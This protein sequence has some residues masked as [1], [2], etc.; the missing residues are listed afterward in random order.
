MS[1]PGAKTS[2]ACFTAGANFLAPSNTL[3]RIVAFNGVESTWQTV[4]DGAYLGRPMGIG[5]VSE[6]L[7]LVSNNEKSSDSVH[8]MG[9]MGEDLGVFASVFGPS[10]I[11]PLPDKGLVA[12]GESDESAV[13][14]FDVSQRAELGRP[15]ELTDAVGLSHMGTLPR[16]SDIGELDSE[17]LTTTSNDEVQRSCI[18]NESSCK[19]GLRKRKLLIDAGA[20]VPMG[21]AILGIGTLRERGS[22]LVAIR[23]PNIH[24]RRVYECPLNEINTPL[25][26]CEIFAGSPT[27]SLTLLPRPHLLF[28]SPANSSPRS[29]SLI[30]R[31]PTGTPGTSKLTRRNAL[32]TCSTTRTPPCTCSPSTASTSG[33]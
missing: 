10:V 30:I 5:C 2:S 3:N 26:G 8:M 13:L 19:P 28:T 25:S 9:V 15:L 4:V 6:T 17:I 22:Y 21:G 32:S 7:C 33:S 29:P 14:F 23:A 18:P 24:E 16:F 11:L 31:V 12:I 20:S 1:H 27:V